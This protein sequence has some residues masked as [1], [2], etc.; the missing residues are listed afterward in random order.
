MDS[1]LALIISSFCV[2]NLRNSRLLRAICALNLKIFERN[3]LRPEL[4]R[5]SLINRWRDSIERHQFAGNVTTSASCWRPET[6]A[7]GKLPVHALSAAWAVAQIEI[8]QLPPIWPYRA[9]AASGAS[10]MRD[11]AAVDNAEHLA[12]DGLRAETT[13]DTGRAAV[14]RRAPLKPRYD[15]RTCSC[16][17]V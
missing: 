2:A 17:R 7:F 3:L 14:H 12:Q 16:R 10:W 11:D 1:H 4:I 5:G 13:T 6:S 15:R 8:R 9:L